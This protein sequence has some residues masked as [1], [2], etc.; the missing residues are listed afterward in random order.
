MSAKPPNPLPYR[1]AFVRGIEVPLTSEAGAALPDGELRA[2]ALDL[3]L[4]NNVLIDGR[5]P[6]LD[7]ITI[8]TWTEVG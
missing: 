5:V 8:I 4:S 1:C 6:T 2:K 3:A 7:D